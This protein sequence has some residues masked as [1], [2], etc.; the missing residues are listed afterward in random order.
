LRIVG[1]L[2]SDGRS[3]SRGGRRIG[4]G[5]ARL[6]NRFGPN[7]NPPL[8]ESGRMGKTAG[9]MPRSFAHLSDEAVVAMLARSD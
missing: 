8:G 4:P 1:L 5:S 7:R 6:P 2:L 3:G 9:L